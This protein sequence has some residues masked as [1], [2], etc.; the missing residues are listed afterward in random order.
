MILHISAY[1]SKHIMFPFIEFVNEHFDKK[2]HFHI[3]C[4]ADKIDLAFKNGTTK[5][6]FKEQEYFIELMEKAEKIILHGIWYEA[7]PKIYQNYTGFLKKTIW[8]IWGG[9]YHNPDDVSIQKKW[10]FKN[11]RYI[12]SGNKFSFEQ[13]HKDYSIDG[14]MINCFM[15]P[16]NL[17]KAH[18]ST[19]KKEN[20]FLN[21]QLGN[22]SSRNNRHIEAFEY[23]KKYKD[24][25]IKI[26]SPLSY[27]DSSYADEVIKKG[28]KLFGDKFIPLKEPLEFDKYIEFLS[29]IDI[30]VFNHKKQESFGNIITHLGFGKKIY[31]D[32]NSEMSD[33]FKEYDLLTFDIQKFNLSKIPANEKKQNIEIVKN[34]FTIKNLQNCLEKVFS[35]SFIR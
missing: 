6:I 25:N 32:E 8:A 33:V 9:E 29:T 35:F 20:A 34:T 16:S 15:Y 12:V 27:G 4:T 22:S 5:D 2:D 1:S 17:F 23:L 24:Y 21:I 31:F 28:K 11:I 14:Q 7:I 10:L 19:Y 30:A 18:L 3:L 26:Y 13:L